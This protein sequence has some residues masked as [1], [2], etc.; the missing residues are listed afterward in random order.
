[1]RFPHGKPI[2]AQEPI[3]A[4]GPPYVLKAM[5]AYVER[6]VNDDPGGPNSS[7][8]FEAAGTVPAWW[9]GAYPPAPGSVHGHRRGGGRPSERGGSLGRASNHI[10][11]GPHGWPGQAARELQTL[12]A[13]ARTE[14]T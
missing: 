3:G 2:G 14:H 9:A 5:S 7:F 4:H 11:Q 12:P 13:I 6:L 8:S 10:A 1:M